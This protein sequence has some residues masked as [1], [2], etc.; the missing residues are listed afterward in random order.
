LKTTQ[1]RAALQRVPRGRIVFTPNAACDG[2][3]FEAPTRFDR[4]FVGCVAP[5]QPRPAWMPLVSHS[6]IGPNDTIDG[7]Y[8][9][10]LERA[11]EQ[12]LRKRDGEPK[13]SELEPARP[14]AST[15]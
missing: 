12:I 8:A 4:L 13:F 15:S 2:D 1:A 11:M 6:E 3:D 14:V 5:A 9:R 10:L 7:D